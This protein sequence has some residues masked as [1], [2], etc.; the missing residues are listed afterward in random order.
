[1]LRFRISEVCD[2]RSATISSSLR[3]RVSAFFFLR[4]CVFLLFFLYA[5]ASLRLYILL[6]MGL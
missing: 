5:S 2:K 1:M 6:V 4:L 3:L